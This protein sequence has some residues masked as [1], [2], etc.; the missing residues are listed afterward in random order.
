MGG[1]DAQ[2]APTII[3]IKFQLDAYCSIDPSHY[4]F[5]I[6]GWVWNNARGCV[7]SCS[8]GCGVVVY[9]MDTL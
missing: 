1:R 6:G 7:G 9:D 8:L 4:G 2:S 5:S 3:R